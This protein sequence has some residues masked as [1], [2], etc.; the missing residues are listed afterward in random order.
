[1]GKI[2]IM[3]LD[4]LLP[5]SNLK[6]KPTNVAEWKQRHYITGYLNKDQKIRI[7]IT[8]V[9]WYE[10]ELQSLKH[11]HD[12]TLEK[13][14]IP[15]I[16]QKKDLNNLTS[17]ELKHANAILNINTPNLPEKKAWEGQK[18]IKFTLE[19]KTHCPH[20]HDEN[21]IFDIR[22]TYDED[23]DIPTNFFES[24]NCVLSKYPFYLAIENCQEKD[25]S[26]EKFW[27]AFDLGIVPIIWGAPNT[28]SYLPHPKSAIFI[29]DFQDTKALADYLKYL[30]KNETAYLEYH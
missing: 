14:D 27:I 26:T 5:L 1:M 11:N 28:R 13:C 9:D 29:E 21:H 12:G 8:E 2:E 24:K 20:C 16:L 19:P 7:Y 18:F 4:T 10:N 23:S 25:Y 6:I 15:C 3:P 22:A 30:A 17:E